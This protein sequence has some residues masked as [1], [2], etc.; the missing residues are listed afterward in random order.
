M[1]SKKFEVVSNG[2]FLLGIIV[3]FLTSPSHEEETGLPSE[4]EDDGSSLNAYIVHVEK[5]ESRVSAQLDDLDSWYH[6]FLPATKAS[7]DKHSNMVYSY[8]HAINGFAA[9][10]TDEEAKAMEKKDGVLLV[11]PATSLQLHTTHSP[12]FLGLHKGVGFGQKANL[13]KGVIIGLEWAHTKLAQSTPPLDED[14]HGTHVSSIAAGNFVEGANLLGNA[15]GT[16]AGV[17]PLA[18]LA[19]YKVCS[20]EGCADSDILAAF[21]TAIEDGVDVLS[22]SIGGG[23]ID[24]F[25]NDII[26]IG[27]IGSLPYCNLGTLT[28]VQLKGEVVL[29]EGG[30]GME[31]IVRGEQVK[32]V[33]GSAMILMNEELDGLTLTADEHVLPATQSPGR[34]SPGILKP[35]IMGPGVNN[36]LAAWPPAS[37]ERNLSFNWNFFTDS[38]TSISC[39]HLCGIAALLK[40]S[41][42]KWS[43][44][45]IKSAIMTTAD[46]LN[47]AGKAIADYTMIPANIFATGAGHVNP[48]KAND[49]GLVYDIQPDDYIPYLCGLKYTDHE[50]KMITQRTMKCMEVKS[51]PEA[52]LNYPSFSVVLRS[53]PQT[54]TRTLT[55]VAQANSSYTLDIIPPQVV[56]VG[57]SPNKLVLKEL[58]QKETYTVTFLKEN[59]SVYAGDQK[60]AQGY[61]KWVS[62]Y[63]F[64]RR[65]SGCK[66]SVR[67]PIVVMFDE[68]DTMPN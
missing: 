18:H 49:P 37:S 67:S 34:I 21:D 29:C 14:G 56:S 39:A 7:L 61:L 6:S 45:A 15:K 11:C 33:G 5:P 26:S 54:F 19:I 51:F 53:S 38:G 17:A 30:G 24:S 3:L 62:S 28:N 50:I 36:I 23:P 32:N 25:L 1:K 16:A 31:G 22:I 46:V 52:Q 68:A 58:N 43:P 27:A 4:V 41:H 59:N 42:P 10:L 12:S 44:A 60:F 2:I 55:N 40:S 47:R 35:E 65:I 20:N 63:K 8:R 48:S 9:R 64:S 13:G 57:M 66:Y